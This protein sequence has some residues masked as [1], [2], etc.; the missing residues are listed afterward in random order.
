MP[1]PGTNTGS[2]PGFLTTTMRLCAGTKIM[3]EIYESSP[4][5][6]VWRFF[7]LTVLCSIMAAVVGTLVQ[8]SVFERAGRNLDEEIGAFEVTPETISFQKEPGTPR[9]F[10][11]PYIT[12]EYYPGNTFA[13]EDFNAGRTSDHG[14]V[15]LPGGLA[16]WASVNWKGEDLFYAS[17]LPASMLYASLSGGK[18]AD[19]NSIGARWEM[20]SGPGFAET[21]KRDFATPGK[22]AENA[23]PSEESAAPVLTTGSQAA[24]FALSMLTAIILLTTFARNF[25]EIGLIVLLVSLVQYLRASTLPK[26]I[27]FRNV[28]TIMVYSTFPAQIAATLFDAAGGDRIIS[29]QLLFVGIF[30]VYQLFAFRAVIRKVCPQIDRKDDDFDDSDF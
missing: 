20:F 1:L 16:S 15:I 21:L 19:L 10:K 28:L 30:F 26:G 3:T 22:N 12:L 17:F 27:I 29:F 23:A 11:L 5:R 4:A 18:N 14:I 7:L 9:R 2:A 8:K 25:L 13:S 6:A 24:S